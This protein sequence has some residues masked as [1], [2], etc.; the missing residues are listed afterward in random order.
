[1]RLML[2]GCALALAAST[3]ACTSSQ[4]TV[5]DSSVTRTQTITP[6]AAAT[7]PVDTSPVTAHDAADCP[8]LAFQQ[9]VSIG[10]M[11]LSRV[12]VL[13]QGGKTVGCRFFAISSGPLAQSEHLHGQNVI[14]IIG[15]RYATA[16]SA[17]N[18]LVVL[19]DKGTDPAQ[20]TIASGIVGVAFRAAFD[21][22]DGTRDWNIAFAKQ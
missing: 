7:G 2:V 14:E 18:A 4:T 3:A 20:Y 10:G 1:M 13:L 9:A 5:I 17:H 19:A 11:R 12:Q 6:T 21:P 8:L 22:G 16:L 15:V